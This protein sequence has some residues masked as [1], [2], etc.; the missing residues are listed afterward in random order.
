MNA[1]LNAEIAVAVEAVIGQMHQAVTTLQQAL[2][3]ERRALDAGSADALDEATSFKQ[4]LLRRLEALDVERKHL[5]R[6]GNVDTALHPAWPT[7]VEGLAR[8]KDMNQINGGIVN[9]RLRHVRKAL[10]L[11]TGRPETSELYGP[12]GYARGA[13]R[14]GMLAQA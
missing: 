11:L 14:P 3:D 5:G 13:A 1:G 2:T 12:G 7:I 4:S 9:Q 10:S 6:A 8:C